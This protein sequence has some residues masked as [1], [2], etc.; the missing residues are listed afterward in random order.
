MYVIVIGAGEVGYNIAQRL[1]EENHDVAVVD[2][3]DSR[4]Q[5]CRDLLDVLT[6]TGS[7]SQEATLR[8][9]GVDRA[10]MLIAV[11]DCDE[12][13]IVACLI[14]RSLGVDRR[15]A[16]V[17]GAGPGV[18]GTTLTSEDFGINHMINPNEETVREIINLLHYSSASEVVEY[19]DGRLTLFEVAVADGAP[20]IGKDLRELVRDD[21]EQRSYLI[22]AI[23]RAGSTLVPHGDDQIEAGD[24]ITVICRREAIRNVTFLA[25]QKDSKINNVMI[26]GGGELGL[27]LARR[28]EEEKVSPI[29]IEKARSRCAYLNEVLEKTLVLQGDGTDIQL[30][31]S[32][33]VDT[34]DAFIPLTPDE[35]NNIVSSLMARHHGCRKVITLIR[36]PDYVSIMPTI[37]LDAAVSKRLSTVSGILRFVRRGSIL[38]VTLF[39]DTDAEVIEMRPS[40]GS[41]MVNRPLH[42]IKFP[43]NALV[44]AVIRGDNEVTEVEVASGNTIIRPGDRAIVF[45]RKKAVRKVEDLFG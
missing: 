37:G 6:V 10:R 19:A 36:R 31:T 23:Q 24:R 8:Q 26:M 39:K 12:V 20:M 11:T 38:S 35:E 34:M 18:Q 9:A 43:P 17:I 25:G 29:I 4:L 7:G 30:L 41:V 32:E 40:T 1:S 27:N 28:L 14:A 5:R 22:V 16:R 44:G 21:E 15:I 2:A 33:G 42:R 13:N 45:A 3:D